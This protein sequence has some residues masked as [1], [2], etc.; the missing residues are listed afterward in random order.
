MI[1]AP[2]ACKTEGCKKIMA[3]DNNQAEFTERVEVAPSEGGENVADPNATEVAAEAEEAEAGAE[4]ADGDPEGGTSRDGRQEQIR[5]PQSASGQSIDKKE[6]APVEGESP[7]E[8]ALRQKVEVFE[9]KERERRAEELAGGSQPIATQSKPK[10]TPE[11]EAIL[12]KYKPEEIASISEVLPVLAKSMGLVKSEDLTQKEYS[13]KALDTINGWVE[14]HPEYKDQ[15]LWDQVKA[16]ADTTYR[17]PI[18]PK[19]WAKILNR[20]HAE[21]SGIQPIGDK[22]ALIAAQRKIQV[23]SHAGASGPTRT[24][25]Q[26]NRSRT[27]TTGLRLDMLQGFSDEEKENIAD[28]A[29]G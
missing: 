23:A 28:R 3:T 22:G 20:I 24:T 26:Q 25:V 6:P 5:K 29:Q 10:L 21:L 18:N 2:P 9:R 11:E 27:N 8:R 7:K 16:I 1:Q 12:K 14:E 4:G 15:T 19:D 17:P 13:S